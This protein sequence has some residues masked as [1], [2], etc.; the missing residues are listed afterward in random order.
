MNHHFN[1]GLNQQ[2]GKLHSHSFCLALC[3][4]SRSW[5]TVT[6]HFLPSNHGSIFPHRWLSLLR[7]SHPLCPLE[8]CCVGMAYLQL[9]SISAM[10]R[11]PRLWQTA[12]RWASEKH[13]GLQLGHACK[14]VPACAG[15]ACP[16]LPTVTN[17]SGHLLPEKLSGISTLP[18][19]TWCV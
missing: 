9:V 1:C 2:A 16:L 19:G 11:T 18:T 14:P 4:H 3:L 17:G 15:P 5:F 10:R 8:V 12:A 13:G 6:P 7:F